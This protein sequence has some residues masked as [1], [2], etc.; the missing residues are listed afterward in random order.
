MFKF[1]DTS[2]ISWNF[3]FLIEN[4]FNPLIYIKENFMLKL[5]Q[6]L[7][8]SALAVTAVSASAGV[9]YDKH[10]N[11]GYDTAEECNKAIANGTAKFYKSSTHHK[12]LKR[13]GEKTVKFAKLGRIS[14]E[15]AKGACDVGTGRR[16]GRDGVAKALQGKYI[17]YSPEMEVN[18]YFDANGNLVRVSMHQCD[19]WFSGAFPKPFKAPYVAPPP[20]PKPVTP[21]P[22]PPPAAVTPPPPPPPPVTPPAV[23]AASGLAGAVPLI[24]GV[25]GV[26]AIAAIV[27]G[28][29]DDDTTTTTQTQKP[30]CGCP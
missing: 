1:A 13:K 22:P 12:P 27:S 8:G 6:V 17:P 11:Q 15:Y 21:P 23:T 18:A 2:V 9:V 28:G 10:G 7:L 26:A 20:P 25:A 30:P 4:S 3:L 19:N 5:Q 29:D 24:A 16:G 14:P